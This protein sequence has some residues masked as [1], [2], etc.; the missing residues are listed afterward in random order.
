MARPHSSK[1]AQHN[2][3]SIPGGGVRHKIILNNVWAC[4]L[5]FHTQIIGSDSRGVWMF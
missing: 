5:A 4:A 1:P 2:A 3:S